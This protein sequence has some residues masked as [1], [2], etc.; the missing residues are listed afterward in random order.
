MDDEDLVALGVNLP[1]L[2]E[3]HL[4]S[5]ISTSSS[6]KA[7]FAGIVQFLFQCKN[8]NI[9]EVAFTATTLPSLDLTHPELPTSSLK[10]LD[11]GPSPINDPEDVAELLSATLP[12]LE[13]VNC[14]VFQNGIASSWRRV[15]D[16]NQRFQRVRRQEREKAMRSGNV[17]LS[18]HA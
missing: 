15:G 2:E 13:S 17:S 7:T 14:R 5:H 12:H 4:P 16:L 10:Q 9:L 3:L 1:R 18:R 8:I 6:I 11:V